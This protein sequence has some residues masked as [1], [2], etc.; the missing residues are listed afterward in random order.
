MV[1]GTDSGSRTVVVIRND[2]AVVC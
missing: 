2:G 1:D